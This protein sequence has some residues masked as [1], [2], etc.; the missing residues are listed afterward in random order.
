MTVL[1]VDTARE[2]RGGQRQLEHLVRGM[3]A[4]GVPTW[5]AAPMN[6]ELARR[7]ESR[8]EPLSA[9]AGAILGLRR[10]VERLAPRIVAV[11]TPHAHG[12]CALAGV[13]PVV[14]RRVDFCLGAWP[15]D[16]WKHRRARGWIAVSAA[17]ALVLRDSGVDP[18]TIRVV[19]D[20]VEAPPIGQGGALSG[21]R[22]VIG[23]I[24]ALVAHK[25]HRVLVDAME[26]LPGVQ[27]V[28]AGEG[29]L[30]KPLQRQIA[31]LGVQD[32][33]RLLGHR[34][35]VGAL[36]A[37]MDLFVHPSLE[38]GM[39]QVVV[40]AMTVGTPVVVSDAGGLP[41]VVGAL[42][43]IVPRGDACA[44]AERIRDRLAKPADVEGLR[45]RATS[46]FS[47]QRMV[48]DTLAAYEAFYCAAR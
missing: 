44:L 42:G 7:L 16:R 26:L 40:E 47:V 12:I 28:I 9:G 38:E 31:A 39:G 29:P 24:G 45:A 43:A 11:H 5:V 23:A 36:L 30:R 25:G 14:H 34:A 48:E 3:M 35:D 19:Y 6:G 21:T 46:L 18:R 22:P 27:C 41:E 37:S 13:L 17:V 33:V 8:V 1:H 15:W 4:R 20:G 32:R 2:W 10:M